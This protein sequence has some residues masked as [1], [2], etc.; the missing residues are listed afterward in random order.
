MSNL[1]PVWMSRKFPDG[2]PP[3]ELHVVPRVT[4][5]CN[6]LPKVSIWARI[7]LLAWIKSWM[8][9]CCDK[10]EGKISSRKIENRKLT[11]IN[12]F[13]AIDI[14]ET[15]I[16]MFW[17]IRTNIKRWNLLSRMVFFLNCKSFLKDWNVP[18]NF[19]SILKLFDLLISHHHSI[20][21]KS[22]EIN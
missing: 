20:I 12:Q 7:R 13:H 15:K 3:Y 14:A 21:Q 16:K 19:F 18:L 2:S 4:S 9:I 17:K 22:K 8:L 5:T 11:E 10:V 1:F 6:G